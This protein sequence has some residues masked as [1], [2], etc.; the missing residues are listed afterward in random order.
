[1]ILTG[2]QL[3]I[4]RIQHD[5]SLTDLARNLNVSRTWLSLVE[6]ERESGEPLR[7]KATLYFIHLEKNNPPRVM[8]A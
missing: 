8:P 1:M 7:S 5:M 2:K 4:K 3:R 6:N